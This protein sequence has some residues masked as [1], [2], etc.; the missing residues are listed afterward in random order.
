VKSVTGWYRLFYKATTENEK[1]KKNNQRH[2]HGVA[3]IAY[4]RNGKRSVSE[5]N[6][7]SIVN[8][9]KRIS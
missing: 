3:A 5:E 9:A 4:R 8:R 1:K 6:S 2:H 7:V